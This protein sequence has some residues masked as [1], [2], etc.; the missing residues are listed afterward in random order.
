MAAVSWIKNMT[1][2][3]LEEVNIFRRVSEVVN[4]DDS[5]ADKSQF[6]RYSAL[7]EDANTPE[8]RV[9]TNTASVQTAGAWGVRPQLCLQSP[10]CACLKKVKLAHLI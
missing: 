7:N 9:T 2:K 6:P 4:R 5:R 8:T 1:S 10:S 3:N